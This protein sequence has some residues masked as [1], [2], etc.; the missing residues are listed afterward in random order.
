MS[1][2]LDS[3]FRKRQI[4]QLLDFSVFY[5][6]NFPD[7]A[8]SK[9]E[10]WGTHW[11]SA[12]AIQAE[13][14]GVSRH[15]F[16]KVLLEIRTKKKFCFIVFVEFL[17]PINIWLIHRQT[18]MISISRWSNR[19]SEYIPPCSWKWRHWCFYL[20]YPGLSLLPVIM[21]TPIAHKDP[22]S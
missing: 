3:M 14:Y 17:S 22:F 12:D 11:R 6:W 4:T 15:L 1:C 5:E 8:D 16:I 13:G 9:S 2:F 19:G 20:T 21:C 10:W 18:F 7:G